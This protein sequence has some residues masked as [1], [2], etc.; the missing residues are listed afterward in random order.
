MREI[1]PLLQIRQ[2]AH[3]MEHDMYTAPRNRIS[4]DYKNTR[5]VRVGFGLN[6]DL[7][8]FFSI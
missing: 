5:G 4:V 8:I 2:V 1:T 3:L 6:L 7:D